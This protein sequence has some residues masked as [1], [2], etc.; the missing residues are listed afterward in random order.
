M[1]K[2]TVVPKRTP[3]VNQVFFSVAN[4]YILQPKYLKVFL[5]MQKVSEFIFTLATLM[6]LCLPPPSFAAATT[7]QFDGSSQHLTLRELGAGVSEAETVALRFRTVQKSAVI[8]ATRDDAST[9]RMEIRMG[10][11]KKNYFP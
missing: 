6:S 9:D 11:E 3:C 7:V 8:M 5:Y 10:E 2:C 4:W 1:S